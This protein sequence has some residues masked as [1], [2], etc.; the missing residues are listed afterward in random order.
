MNDSDIRSNFHAKRLRRY[1]L[2][3]DTLVLDELGLKHGNVRA[4]IA[5]VNGHLIGYEIKSD[6]DSLNR[7]SRQVDAYSAVF[8]RANAVV[9]QRHSVPIAKLVPSWWG[10]VVATRGRRG[11]VCFKT[12]RRASPNPSTDAFATAQLLWRNEAEEELAK[13]GFSGRILRQKRSILYEELIKALGAVELRMVV[14]E[15]LKMRTDWRRPA[16]SSPGDGSKTRIATWEGSP[17][18]E[19]L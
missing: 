4:D 14:K 15:R 8:D 9:G 16:Q 18:S 2:S 5:V 17:V 13:R 12:I 11:A 6:A 1:H 10:I 3:P 7:L 19:R